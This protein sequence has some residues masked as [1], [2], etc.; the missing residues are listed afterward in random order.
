MSDPEPRWIPVEIAGHAFER[1][2]L[3]HEEV[4]ARVVAEI[5][6]DVDVYYDRRWPL[7]REFCAFLLA[8]PE[9]ATGRTVFAAGV[10]VGMEAVVLGRLADAVVVNDLAPV[11]L[12]LAVEQ[13][14]RNGVEPLRVEGGAFQDADL[15]GVDLVVACFVVYD[16]GTRD[17]MARLLERARERGIPALLANEDIGGF[18]EEVLEGLERPVRHLDP[19]GR[20]RI[21]AVS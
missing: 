8:R 21:V 13:L 4:G 14:R 1:I 7:T 2:N 5:E 20:R 17:A 15:S 6:S 12:E 10:G 11:A 18:F 9:L 3:E 19:E 16:A